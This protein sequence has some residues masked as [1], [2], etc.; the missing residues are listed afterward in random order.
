[1]RT[2]AKKYPA[3]PV[4]ASEFA[5]RHREIAGRARRDHLDVAPVGVGCRDTLLPGAGPIEGHSRNFVRNAPDLSCRAS[6]RRLG[7]VLIGAADPHEDRQ[8]LPGE[9]TEADFARRSRPAFVPRTT[10]RRQETTRTVGASNPQVRSQIRVSSL[11]AKSAPRTLS[12]W[13]HG[14]EPR[15]D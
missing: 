5:R 8:W 1:M 15:W 3:W 9:D 13:R 11:V 14:F 10:G 7:V 2:G 4:F 12:R 6:A